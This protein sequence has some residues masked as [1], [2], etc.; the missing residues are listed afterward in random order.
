MWLCS[1]R[2]FLVKLLREFLVMFGERD[3][4]GLVRESLFI[5]GDGVSG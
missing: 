2:E 1:V 4:I 3:S 5:F